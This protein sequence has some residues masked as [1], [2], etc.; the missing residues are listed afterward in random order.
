[1]AKDNRTVAEAKYAKA[2]LRAREAAQV[3]TEVAAEE[4]RVADNTA[5]LRALRLARDAREAEERAANL[6]PAKKKKP[7]AKAK[8]IPVR[9]LNAANDG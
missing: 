9:K 7:A 3:M 8:S 4:K 1:M 2:Q 6:P 5:R